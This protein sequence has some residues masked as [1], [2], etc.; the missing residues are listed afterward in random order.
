MSRTIRNFRLVEQIG[1]GGVGIV[2]KAI[3]TT[4]DRPVAVKELHPNLAKDVDFIR[5]FERE[6]KA[7]AA[8]THESLVGVIDFGQEGDTYF[9]ALE[10]VDGFDL[11]TLLERLGTNQRVSL[12]IAIS[13]LAPILH[14]LEHAHEK[15]IVHRDVKPGNILVAK[16]GVVKLGDFSAAFGGS[17]PAVSVTG[18]TLGTPAYMSPEQA[19][20]GRALDGR[21]DVFAV[22]VILWELIAGRRPFEGDSY[23]SVIAQIVTRDPPDLATV[24]PTVP[25]SI[26]RIARKAL[27]KDRDRRYAKAGDFARDLEQAAKELGLEIGREIVREWA[28]DPESWEGAVRRK[29]AAE[30][31]AR[32][33]YL[34]NQG[35]AKGE[36]AQSVLKQAIDLDPAN[37][38]A[39]A[40]FSELA[41][42]RMPTLLTRPPPP[43]T[44]RATFWI[45]AS[46]LGLALTAIGV[47]RLSEEEI[48]EATPGESP[49]PLVTSTGGTLAAATGTGSHMAVLSTSGEPLVDP[50]ASDTPVD[51]TIARL[52]VK[53]KPTW[54]HVEVDGRVV[55]TTPTA[56]PIL[57]PAG[58]HTVV[59]RNPRCDEH[60]ESVELAPGATLSRTFTLTCR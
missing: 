15:R 24:D 36:E 40:A 41:S 33:R 6:A 48:A 44:N 17:L 23:G 1:A 57:L 50:E 14:G 30:L 2:W 47:N 60:S 42:T 3:Q 43:R 5:R 55:A 52:Y 25:E 34:M 56:I 53:V 16:S 45:G 39:R 46:L 58:P 20:G 13:L 4:L 59:L 27:Q 8:L 19:E 7:A 21:S 12:A 26:V 51:E 28:R 32:G 38:S 29:R 11:R 35:A 10:Y 9:L 37:E 54:A 49:S 18:Q 31:V 22:G